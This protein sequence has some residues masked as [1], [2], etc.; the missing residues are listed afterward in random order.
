MIFE[1]ILEG[2]G[3]KVFKTVIYAAMGLFVIGDFVIPRHH[4]IFPWDAIPG[5]SAAYGLISCVAIITVAKLI[6]K[7]WLQRGEDYYD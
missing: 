7:L 2:Y 5:F 6:G 3:K 1:K 4:A